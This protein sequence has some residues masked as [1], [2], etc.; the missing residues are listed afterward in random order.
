MNNRLNFAAFALW[1]FLSGMAVLFIL[2]VVFDI[3]PHGLVF[4]GADLRGPM[5]HEN[6]PAAGVRTVSADDQ[7]GV[8]ETRN[9]AIVQA[10]EHVNPSVV[11]IG[12]IVQ[13]RYIDPHYRDYWEYFFRRE[14]DTR[15]YY[16][17]I[18]TGFLINAEGVIVTNYHVIEGGREVIVTLQDGREVPGQVIGSDKTLDIAVVKIEGSGFPYAPLGDSDN[19]IIGEW[20]IAIGNPYGSLLQDNRPTVT[21]GVIS[22]VNRQFRPSSEDGRYYQNMIQTDAAINP[23]NSG[24]PLIN[25][26]GEVIGINTFIVSQSGGNI[27]LGF[28]IPINTAKRV[29]GEILTYGKVRDVWLGFQGQEIGSLLARS[30]SRSSTDGVIVTYIEPGGP[31]EAGGLQRGDVIVAMDG[32][33]VKGATDANAK[34]HSLRVGDRL[35]VSVERD[36]QAMRVEIVAR[37]SPSM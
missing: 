19:L 33:P 23:G 30:L 5:W 25:S 26:R 11:S 9:S 17:K 8:D 18:G 29:V 10:I 27:G 7:G 34:I 14:R 28:A 37:E 31:A 24:G 13:R 12:I 22:A 35:E 2:L 1:Y 3:D 32:I 16:P 21:V 6:Q 4:P 36:G 15:E 20:A